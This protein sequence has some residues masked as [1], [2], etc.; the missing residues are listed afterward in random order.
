MQTLLLITLFSLGAVLGSALNALAWR[1][2]VG[3][4]WARGRSQCPDCEHQ[5]RWFELVPLVSF[6]I[7]RG[8][9]H[10]C[11]QPISLQYPLVELAAGGLAALSFTTFGLTVGG[12]LSLLISLLLLFIYI[13]DGRTMMIP[14]PAVWSFNLLAFG[15]LFFSFDYSFLLGGEP[16]A[17]PGWWQLAAGP[18]VAL[19]LFLIWTGSR[20]RAMGFGDVKLALGLGWLLG[21]AGGISALVF[22]FW[23]GAVVSLGL[24]GYQRLW[25]S[26][27]LNT[28]PGPTMK[29][30]DRPEP[31]LS[32][33]SAVPFGPFLI[34]GWLIVFFSN[35]TL[36]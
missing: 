16:F 36:F 4:G 7:L 24:L 1:L 2:E 34:L 18:L 12:V 27:S 10:Q 35:L 30:D 8:S 3:K 13:Y 11:A 14:D 23:I 19:P 5:L 20:G 31:A 29:P 32:M 15:A 26:P 25:K 6:I 28:P 17:L 33:Q 9:C 22:A 21:I